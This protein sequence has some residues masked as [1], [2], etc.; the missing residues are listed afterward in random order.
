M[1]AEAKAVEA[2]VER[3]KKIT[4]MKLERLREKIEDFEEDDD[5]ESTP[6]IKGE[7]ILGEMCERVIEAV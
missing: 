3:E 2:G 7:K 5:V 1:P 4:G 6:E